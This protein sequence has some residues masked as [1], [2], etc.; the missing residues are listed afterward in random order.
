MNVNPVVIRVLRSPLHRLLSRTTMLVTYTGRKSGHQITVPVNYVAQGEHVWVLSLT[1]RTWWRNFQPSAPAT[2]RLRGRNVSVQG[3]AVQ[4]E[5]ELLAGLAVVVKGMPQVARY[6]HIWFDENGVP[7]PD[8]LRDA[9]KGR[10][11][12]RF[13]P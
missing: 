7:D 8:D 12:L 6:L 11:L 3:T 2:L 10:V 9:L 4:D 13:T 1:R 5:A